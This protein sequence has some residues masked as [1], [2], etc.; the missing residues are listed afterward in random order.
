MVGTAI[1][2]FLSLPGASAFADELLCAHQPQQMMA[3]DY[4]TFAY[5]LD[6]GFRSLKP[7]NGVCDRTVAFLIQQYRQTRGS[8]LTPTEEVRLRFEEAQRF[9]FSGDRENA[10]PLYEASKLP[11]STEWNFYVEGTIAFVRSDAAL[12]ASI[13]AR[14]AALPDPPEFADIV[15]ERKNAGVPVPIYR[16]PLLIILDGYAEC[17]DR[18]HRVAFTVCRPSQ[19]LSETWPK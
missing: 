2:V 19:T 17:F 11:G 7:D 14:F 10:I 4:S 18:P 16:H 9:S 12:L 5:D 13:R 3:L 6:R 8:K 15:R 1:F